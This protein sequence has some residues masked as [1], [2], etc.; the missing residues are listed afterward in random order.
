MTE[1]AYEVGFTGYAF[2]VER[3][4]RD[5]ARFP[6]GPTFA[7]RVHADIFL[8][9]LEVIADRGYVPPGTAPATTAPP[10]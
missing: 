1:A 4:R 3:V 9:G 7:Y 6:V 8:L 10:S 2:Q 5:G